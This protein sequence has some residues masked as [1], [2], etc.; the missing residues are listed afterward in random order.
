M[1]SVEYGIFVVCCQLHVAS[2]MC[3]IAPSTLLPIHL[4]CVVLMCAMSGYVREWLCI[5]LLYFFFFTT[6]P[7]LPHFPHYLTPLTR[8][9]GV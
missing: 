1:V 2:C 6:T 8:R 3:I 7:L 4:M 9:K 5:T